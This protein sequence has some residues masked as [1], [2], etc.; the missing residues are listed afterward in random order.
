MNACPNCP[1][2]NQ[3]S[4][5]NNFNH[6]RDCTTTNYEGMIAVI[7]PSNESWVNRYLQKGII[8]PLDLGNM[9]PGIYAIKLNETMNEDILN[10]FENIF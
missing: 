9:V 8:L 6:S 3:Y 1:L 2:N 4:F 7:S 5:Q 10:Y